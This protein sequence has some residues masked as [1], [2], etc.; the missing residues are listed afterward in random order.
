MGPAWLRIVPVSPGARPLD[1]GMLLDSGETAALQVARELKAD[2]L[3]MDERKGRAVAG[4]LGIAV[5]GTLG[6][7]VEAALRGLIDFDEVIG[8][9]RTKTNFWADDAVI[10]A[11]RRRVT[12]TLR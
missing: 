6:V 2:L 12:S 8:V 9:L 4:R 11:A 1:T 5:T 3:L 10:A 7:L